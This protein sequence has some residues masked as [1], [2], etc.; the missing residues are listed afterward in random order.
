MCGMI[1]RK[2]C[3]PAT[4]TADEQ[5]VSEQTPDLLTHKLLTT[6]RLFLTSKKNYSLPTNCCFGM[7]TCYFFLYTVPLIWTVMLLNDVSYVI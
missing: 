1:N 7:Q 6:M 3:Q 2:R 5:L 4:W